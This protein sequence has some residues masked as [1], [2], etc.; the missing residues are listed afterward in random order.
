MEVAMHY[1]M[2]L[3]L[4]VAISLCAPAPAH[5][6]VNCPVPPQGAPCCGNPE[7]KSCGITVDG[8]DRHFCI[9]VPAQPRATKPRPVIVGFHGGAGN[10]A[11]TVDWL[12]DL[13]EQG[14]VLIA[15]TAMQT[16]RG[17]GVPCRKAWRA[18]GGS[19][20]D[21]AGFNNVAANC[22]PIPNDNDLALTEALIVLKSV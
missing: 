21:W 15:P 19:V 8:V 1:I 3:I 17:P 4:S 2:S 14:I 12:D 10:A 16:E 20:S 13:T 9:H 11:R 7:F 5:A 6:Q 18:I 22:T